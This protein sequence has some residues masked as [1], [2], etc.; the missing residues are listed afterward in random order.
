[1]ENKKLEKLLRLLWTSMH[2]GRQV[3]AFLRLLISSPSDMF[4]P[5][6][7]TKLHGITS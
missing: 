7:S 2:F 5:I 1:L 3:P 4:I 6:H